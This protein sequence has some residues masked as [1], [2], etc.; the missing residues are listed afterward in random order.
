[1]HQSLFCLMLG[2]GIEAASQARQRTNYH[3]T[4]RTKAL[5]NHIYL[6][7]LTNKDVFKGTSILLKTSFSLGPFLGSFREICD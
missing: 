7:V 2:R 1:M 5:S 4:T 3:V 6:R